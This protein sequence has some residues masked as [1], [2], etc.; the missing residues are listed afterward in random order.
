[1]QP[2]SGLRINEGQDSVTIFC[3]Y[4]AN[5]MALLPNDTKWFKDGLQLD[6]SSSQYLT[7][8]GTGGEYPKLTIYDLTRNDTGDYGCEVSNLMGTGRPKQALRLDVFF[9]PSVVLQIYPGL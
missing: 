2:Q 9:V 1:M 4:D 5:P 3:T 6:T 8:G 7:S